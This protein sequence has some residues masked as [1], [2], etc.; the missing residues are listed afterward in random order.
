MDK[1]YTKVKDLRP[2][3]KQVN[4]LGKV[5]SIGEEREIQPRFGGS[6]KL[7]EATIG[8][9]TGTVLLTLWENQIGSVSPD[10]T[11]EIDNG[12]VTLVRGHVRLNVG[13]YGSISKSEEAIDEVNTDLDVSAEE[14][15]SEPRHDRDRPF[16]DRESRNDY[17]DGPRQFIFGGSE[18]SGGR[19][20]RGRRR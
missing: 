1:A 7:A 19:R 12:Y 9:E 8:D 13:K 6:R 15:Q 4:V 10:E 14:H 2:E 5:V 11:I 3:S 17:Q 20:D 18:F 16:R